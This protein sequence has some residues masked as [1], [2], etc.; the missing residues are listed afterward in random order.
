MA[1]RISQPSNIP[2][3]ISNTTICIFSVLRV[4]YQTNCF[5]LASHV[6]KYNHSVWFEVYSKIFID[7]K[8]EGK[9]SVTLV[10]EKAPSGDEEGNKKKQL[11]QSSPEP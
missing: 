5:W 9:K 11:T 7:L 8:G 2:K 1:L 6:L 10:V 4:L 3:G